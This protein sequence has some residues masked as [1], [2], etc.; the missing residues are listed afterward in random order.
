[1]G[2]ML[3]A[4]VSLGICVSSSFCIILDECGIY[5]EASDLGRKKEGKICSAS[6]HVSE[7]D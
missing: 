2:S 6:P 7:L 5:I 4:V 3:R 1:M